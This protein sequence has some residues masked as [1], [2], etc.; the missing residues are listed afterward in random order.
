MNT[1]LENERQ[2]FAARHA[3]KSS[4]SVPCDWRHAKATR[5]PP[6]QVRHRS[7]LALVELQLVALGGW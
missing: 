6:V 4:L 3:A 5:Q 1:R 2:V 7:K